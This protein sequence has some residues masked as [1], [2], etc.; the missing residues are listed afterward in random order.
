LNPPGSAAWPGESRV[1]RP[2]ARPAAQRGRGGPVRVAMSP[3][4]RPVREGCWT[5]PGISGSVAAHA[6]R[7]SARNRRIRAP[8]AEGAARPLA[9][10]ERVRRLH[11]ARPSHPRSCSG[12]PAFVGCP[13]VRPGSDRG[14]LEAAATRR[15]HSRTPTRNPDLNDAAR[16]S[17]ALEG[18]T[19]LMRQYLT[20][21]AAHPD[22]LLFFR[23]GDF[24]ELFY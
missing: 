7:G 21:K 4:P 24:Y 9:E 20:A 18:H 17:A 13:A 3:M 22:V 19:P 15:V 6:P 14:R 23:M 16:P 1:P 5:N 10:H 2:P 12:R 8:A 11:G